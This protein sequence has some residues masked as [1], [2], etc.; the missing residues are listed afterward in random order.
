MSLWVP[1]KQKYLNLQ[2]NEN[3]LNGFGATEDNLSCRWILLS[4]KCEANMQDLVQSLQTCKATEC[5]L[6]PLWANAN[7]WQK[8]TVVAPAH[9]TLLKWTSPRERHGLNKRSF[10][11]YCKYCTTTVAL[12]I[13]RSEQMKDPHN[14]YEILWPHLWNDWI[15]II[16][17]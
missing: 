7:C 8:I 17:F 1:S 9:C 4:W 10:H 2:K 6:P 12:K 5:C 11:R 13:R 16:P 15:Q 3:I 14:V